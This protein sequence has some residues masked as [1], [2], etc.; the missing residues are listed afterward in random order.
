VRAGA[1][2]A[3]APVAIFAVA[4]AGAAAVLVAG[5]TRLLGVAPREAAA[6]ARDF[7]LWVWTA[8]QAAASTHWPV[9]GA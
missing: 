9:A 2:A 6:L 3:A 8:G 7:A 5:V 4:L 1:A